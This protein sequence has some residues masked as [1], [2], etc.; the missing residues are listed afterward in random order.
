MSDQR[1]NRPD[2]LD[3]LPGPD[4][5]DA[6]APAP[7]VDPRVA[8]AHTTDIVPEDPRDPLL[9]DP[10]AAHDEREPLGDPAPFSTAPPAGEDATAA[11]GGDAPVPVDDELAPAPSDDAALAGEDASVRPADDVIVPTD[12]GLTP[13]RGDAETTD[14]VLGDDRAGYDEDV[15]D[16]AAEHGA[17]ERAADEV[18]DERV[19]DG[20]VGDERVADEV[21]RPVADRYVPDEYATDESAVYEH[22]DGRRDVEQDALDGPDVDERE[23]ALASTAHVPGGQ[24]PED[25]APLAPEAPAEGRPLHEVPAPSDAAPAAVAAPTNGWKVL[26]QALR[27][28]VTRA[29]LLAG[30]LCA[31]LGFALAVQIRQTSDLSLSGMRQD[32]LVRILDETTTRG[33]SLE[34]ERADLAVERD[35]LLSG[36]D[37]RQAALDALRRSAETQGILA[38]RLPAEGP[39]V[40]VTLTEPGGSIK[41]VMMLNVLEEL[42]NAGAEAIQLDDQRIT[43][44]SA[45]TGSAGAVVLDGVTLSPPYVWTVI[46]DPE[47]IATALQMPGGAFAQVRSTGADANVEQLEQVEVTAIRDIPDPVHATPV[48][49]AAD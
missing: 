49:A 48:P 9:D 46:G 39:G 15:A 44:S 29:Q 7:D 28:R 37:T 18:A 10:V 20:H 32:D 27:P 4:E 43:A 41:P 35:E 31:L 17:E 22:A 11:P 47:T 3:G 2:D 5:Q 38:G 24:D 40:V 26:G 19:A 42:R 1:P 33:D 21:D 14:A 16:D 30:V 8:D 12:A 45:F 13:A 23:V 36:S 25:R 6:V 34:R